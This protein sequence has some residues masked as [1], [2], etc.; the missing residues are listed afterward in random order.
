M[1][2]RL[3]PLGCR[4]GTFART[5]QALV[6]RRLKI[7]AAKGFKT[8]WLQWQIDLLGTA[9]D[10]EL[11]ARFG[12]SRSAV[13]AMRWRAAVLREGGWGRKG[14]RGL[15]ADLRTLKNLCRDDED[16]STRWI[17]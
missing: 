14:L 4:Q 17:G 12:P 15:S 16:R 1:R 3:V 7:R 9:S 2:S 8:G 5:P 11:A 13:R 10:A 6:K